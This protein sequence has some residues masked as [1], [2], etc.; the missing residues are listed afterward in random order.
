MNET[1][2]NTTVTSQTGE[3]W[4]VLYQRGKPPRTVVLDG[5]LTIGR[6][7][8][9]PAVAGHLAIHDDPAVSRLH[10]VL[11][12]RAPGWCVQA[13]NSTNGLFVNGTRLAAGA[14]HLLANA[15]EI[16]LGER[17][18]LA[19]HSL[20]GGGD[21]SLTQTAGGIPDLT[22]AERRVLLCLCSPVLDGDA[23]T[24]PAT[25]ATIASML[26]VTDSAVKQQLVRLYLKFGVDD[27]PDRRVRLANDALTRGAVRRA[28]LQSFRASP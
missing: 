18:A 8:D 1:L 4:L 27:G 15:D 23:F 7:I 19:F 13:A 20:G 5:E 16:R 28:D 22:P 26:Y 12:R 21:R 6:H 25:V 17:T 3:A 11:T 24:P 10:A 9:Q 2:D 14:V